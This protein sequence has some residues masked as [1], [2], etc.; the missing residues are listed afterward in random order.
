MRTFRH[1]PFAAFWVAGFTSNTG[2]WL[3]F[4]LST[5]VV[6]GWTGS[7]AALGILGAASFLPLLLFTLPAGLLTDRWDRRRIVTTTQAVAMMGSLLLAGSVHVGLRSAEAVGAGAF[8]MYTCYALSK[9]ALSSV[10]PVLVP[11]A[12]IP[13]ATA[14]NALSFTLGQLAGPLVAAACVAAGAPALGFALNGLSYLGVIVVMTRVVPPAD[15]HTRAHGSIAA[16]LGA[17]AR[18]LRSGR[19][20]AAML[21]VVA[22]SVPILDVVRMFAPVLTAGVGDTNEGSAALLAAALG[23]GAATGQLL[24]SRLL[25]TFAPSAILTPSLVG[26]GVAAVGIALAGT[27]AMLL[28]GS[29]GLGAMYGV[30]FATSTGSIQAV[31]PDA[32]RGRVMSVHAMVH[33]GLRPIMLPVAGAIAAVAGVAGALMAFVL[34]LPMGVAAAV[35]AGRDV[36]AQDPGEPE[37]SPRA[38]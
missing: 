10:F 18:Y 12:E 33:L 29:L 36:R 38:T 9:P 6:Y 5:I 27:E 19:R 25:G 17:A 14:L 16:D 1:R 23:A 7:A 28:L 20:V 35:S 15:G 31:V 4:V 8:L 2:T 11:K 26:M 21:V 3:Q 30:V 37:V 13:Q 22:V 32:L 24:T 34:I